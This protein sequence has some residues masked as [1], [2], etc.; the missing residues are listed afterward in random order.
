MTLARLPLTVWRGHQRPYWAVISSIRWRLLCL[1]LGSLMST[2]FSV[3]SFVATQ[4]AGAMYDRSRFSAQ[5]TFLVCAQ[6]TSTSHASVP[7]PGHAYRFKVFRARPVW[8]ERT[9]VLALC[10]VGVFEFLRLGRAYVL[11]RLKP[12]SPLV[13]SLLGFSWLPATIPGA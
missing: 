3:L 10:G 7:W 11:Q 5:R 4:P 1:P 9:L 8:K 12:F 2:H 6:A 13:C